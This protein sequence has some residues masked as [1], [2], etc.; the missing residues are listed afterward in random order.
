MKSI[1]LDTLKNSDAIEII[2]LALEL[3]HKLNQILNDIN[4]WTLNI[5]IECN[6]EIFKLLKVKF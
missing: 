4:T 5:Q 6:E 2:N 1:S 3:R